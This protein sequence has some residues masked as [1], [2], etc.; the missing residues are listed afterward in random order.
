MEQLSQS[1]RYL[2]LMYMIIIGTKAQ[3]HICQ[4]PSITDNL[5][6]QIRII[7]YYNITSLCK[8]K[9]KV[10]LSVTGVYFMVRSGFHEYEEEKLQHFHLIFTEPGAHQ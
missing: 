7:T 1:S 3:Q 9:T 4:V 10:L 6:L 2:W 5:D 8:N